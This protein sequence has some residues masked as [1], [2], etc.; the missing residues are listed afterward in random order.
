MRKRAAGFLVAL[1]L[2]WLGSAFAQTP[3]FAAMLKKVDALATF[4]QSDFSAECMVIQTIPGEGQTINRV[5]LFRRDVQS[6]YLMLILEPLADRG[7][8]YLKIGQGLWLYQ[9]KDRN[10]EFTS[11]KERFQNSN[12]RNS[13]FTHSS[14]STDYRVTAARQETLGSRLCWVIDLMA[15][16]S[17]VTFPITRIWVSDD[18]LVRKTED[19]SL[20][21]QLL[22]T[23]AMPSYQEVGSRFVPVTITIVD[24][25]RGRKIKGKFNSEVT[26][27]SITKPSLAALPSELFTKAFLEK[28]AK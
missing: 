2:L 18:N 13:D 27:I 24:A 26:E 16:T 12:A 25:L 7:K 10:F 9:P 15:T 8:G 5:A 19:Y 20:S 4:D 3:D 28:F 11:S 1:S 21:K 23:T 17:D 6:K 22:R 14:F